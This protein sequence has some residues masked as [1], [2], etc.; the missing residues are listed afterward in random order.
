M[1]VTA[2]GAL[3]PSFDGDGLLTVDI[4][5][6]CDGAYAVAVQPDDTIVVAGSLRPLTGLYL[7]CA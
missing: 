5:G 1:R 7:D 4:G 6:N 3:D 2:N